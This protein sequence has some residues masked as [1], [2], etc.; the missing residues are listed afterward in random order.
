MHAQTIAGGSARGPR[1]NKLYGPKGLH[2]DENQTIFFVDGSNHRIMKYAREATVGRKVFGRGISGSGP[3]L[4]WEPSDIVFDHDSISL[5][6]SDSHNRRV[7]RCRGRKNTE[8]LIDDISCGGLAIDDEGFLYVSD[9][10]HH[11]VRR[12]P[13]GSCYGT[14]V[15]GGNG[16]GSRLSQLN[17]PTYICVGPDQAVYISDVWND[18][19]V[20]WC[21]GATQG[22]VVTGGKRK[23]R[24]RTQLDGPAGLIVDQQGAV[25]VADQKN[26][27]V[28]RFY[29][30]ASHGE[31]IAGDKYV[32]GNSANKLNEP[33]GLAFDS[34]GNLYVA[35]SNNHRIQRFD[36]QTT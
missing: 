23:G 30:G 18:R 21:K 26:H 16:Q 12:Y 35:D 22:I 20:K 3:D 2:M 9:T 11:E 1:L 8:T 17:H 4:L 34:Y 36:I 14:V 25:Y 24:D 29:K 15:A 5:I 10:E 33:A 7:L 28:M 19:I 27:R 32:V 6:I 31:I 13:A